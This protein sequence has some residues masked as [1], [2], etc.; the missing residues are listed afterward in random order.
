MARARRNRA[1]RQ[2][3]DFG[4]SSSTGIHN[5]VDFPACDAREFIFEL[6]RGDTALS[7]GGGNG[8]AFWTQAN[9]EDRQEAQG[10]PEGLF[11]GKLARQA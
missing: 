1:F 11:T 6:R 5:L 2:R 8:K 4:S 10:G 9:Y 3:G 7:L